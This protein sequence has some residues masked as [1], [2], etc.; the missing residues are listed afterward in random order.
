MTRRRW[1]IFLIAWAMLLLASFVALSGVIPIQASSGHWPI[2]TWVLDLIKRRSVNTY[3]MAIDAPPLD[4]TDLVVR[5]AATYERNCRRCHGSPAHEPGSSE[6]AMTPAPPF[7]P[8]SVGRWTDAELF[9]IVKHGIKFTGMP[10]WPAPARNDEVWA[11]VAFLRRLDELPA[12][13]YWRLAAG[14]VDLSRTPA[15]PAASL[16]A[17]CHGA[18]GQGRDGGGFPVIAGQSAGYLRSSLEA[19]A[20]LQR[21]SG[22]MAPVATALD[23]GT[24][25]ALARHY[26]GLPGPAPR[27]I[28][29]LAA[30]GEEIARQGIPEQRVPACVEC[31]RPATADRHPAYPVLHGQ[32]PEYL[33]L[34]L[35]L[36]AEDA[37]GGGP[38]AAIM[39][40]IAVRLTPQ[41]REAVAAYFG[42][43][44]D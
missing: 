12:R 3:A 22:V 20:R 11:V 9:Q 27:R 1:H 42:S 7:L 10:A 24:I 35:Q 39:R 36:F 17:A 41:Q 38:A 4:R 21:H 14:A 16:C 40:P 33:L 2:T 30:R 34:Q 28:E 8:D 29:G 25:E 18:D 19:Y 43:G 15:T 26:S 32:H 5:G 37:R 44:V 23:A 13:D 31:H 6:A